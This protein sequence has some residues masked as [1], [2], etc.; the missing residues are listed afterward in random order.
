MPVQRKTLAGS[1]SYPEE[2]GVSIANQSG[3][4]PEK[5]IWR[6]R[7]H[8]SEEEVTGQVESSTSGQVGPKPK[9]TGKFKQDENRENFSFRLHREETGFQTGGTDGRRGGHPP[10]KIIRYQRGCPPGGK[11]ASKEKKSKQEKK[12][13]RTQTKAEYSAVRLEQA[14]DR[15]AEQKPYK[16]PGP[17]KRAAT[18]AG[19]S[20]WAYGHRKIHEAEHENVGVE[21]A[22]KT[23][24]LGEA[25]AHKASRYTKRRIREHPARQVEN[26]SARP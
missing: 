22:H 20:V 18:A 23:E 9:S 19:A 5:R 7:L 17:V 11:H 3:T 16:P 21:A 4:L 6:G 24:L 14:R 25:G 13:E 12:Q 26:G 1:F 8:F 2:E 15:L 10:G